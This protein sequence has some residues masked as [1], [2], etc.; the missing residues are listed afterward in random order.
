MSESNSKRVL[1]RSL[2]AAPAALAGIAAAAAV[3]APRDAE[4][5]SDDL[6]A[7]VRQLMSAQHYTD[8]FLQINDVLNRYCRGWDRWD[9]AALRSCFH[10]DSTHQHGGFKGL[11]SDFLTVAW[12]SVANVK[13][14]TH[15]CSNVSIEVAGDSAVSECYFLAHHRQPVKDGSGDEDWF[16]MGRYVDRFEKRDGLWKIAHRRGLH[17]YSRHIS[18]ADTE[19]DGVPAEQIS[20]RK[21]DDPLY[22][23]LAALH[24]QH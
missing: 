12:K 4:A 1:L 16:L 15:Y 19:L 5:K 22:T 14:M 8:A 9:E 23:M 6:E 2:L 24:G 21:P 18:P 13:S 20:G 17:D 3:A 7:Q 11:S 10:P